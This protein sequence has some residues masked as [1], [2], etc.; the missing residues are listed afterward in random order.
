M[1][2][3]QFTSKLSSREASRPLC[4]IC[5]ARVKRL[6]A[7]PAR[8]GFEHWT[9]RC[10]RM[11]AHSFGAGAS[12]PDSNTGWVRRSSGA[13]IIQHRRSRMYP[14]YIGWRIMICTFLIV[15]FAIIWNVLGS[16]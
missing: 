13:S 8:P 5:Q 2:H 10:C 1:P 7:V 15:M 16:A 4:P 3:S 12:R 11:R 9:L 6:R 14:N